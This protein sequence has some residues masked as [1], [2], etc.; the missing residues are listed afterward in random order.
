MNCNLPG[1]PPYIEILHTN[2]RQ[3]CATFFILRYKG[4]ENTKNTKKFAFFK[5]I[6]YFQVT[7]AHLKNKNVLNVNCE[8]VAILAITLAN[9]CSV[10]QSGFKIKGP[11]N[12]T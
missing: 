5:Q 9:I 2:D 11:E 10:G 4:P 7:P 1:Q 8:V 6:A 12:A 3:C